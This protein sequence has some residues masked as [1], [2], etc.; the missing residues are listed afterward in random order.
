MNT[1]VYLHLLY[2]QLT[3]STSHSDADLQLA[4][5]RWP[6]DSRSF[7]ASCISLS[8]T[9]YNPWVSSFFWTFGP[10]PSGALQLV[11]GGIRSS[12]VSRSVFLSWISSHAYLRIG[13][14][15]SSAASRGCSAILPAKS[16]E[17]TLHALQSPVRSYSLA[18]VT[19]WSSSCFP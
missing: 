11:G 8:Q 15:T 3:T 4:P 7:S 10:W 18:T 14:K 16:I 19:A 12:I 17:Y 5:H 13:S 1:G 2:T 9:R 6:A